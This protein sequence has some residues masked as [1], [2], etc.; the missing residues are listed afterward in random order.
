MEFVT[1]NNGEKMPILG[2]GTYNLR[3]TRGYNAI[4]SAINVGY[5]LIDT[6]QMYGNEIEVGNAVANAIKFGVPREEFFITTKLSSNMTYDEVMKRFED[7]MRKLQL[8]YLDLLLIHSNYRNAKEMYRA[9][10][11]LHKEGKIKSLGVSN[12]NA[13][14]FGDFIKDCEIIPAVNQC[15]T[16]IFYQQRILR[17]AMKESGTI[18][19]SWSPFVSGQSNF[20]KNPTL[21]SVASKYNKSV[22]Q[23][24]LRFL[25]QQGIVVIPKTEN[26]LRMRENLAVFDFSLSGDDMDTLS[27]M[28][29]GKSS[30]SWDSYGAK[31]GANL[32][33]KK[34][35]SKTTR[36]LKVTLIQMYPKPYALS[37]NLRLALK[38][39][40][41]SL[42]KGAN[43]IVF[44]EL[45]DS[46]YCVAPC[47]KD[48][49]LDFT[50]PKNH[51]TFKA[52]S[53]FA[54]ENAVHIVACGIEKSG[55]KL[56]DTAYIIAPS[57]NIIGKH[58]KIYLW[59]DEKS[60][61]YKGKKYEVF[62]LD[63][64]GFRAKVGLQIC[65]E[66]GFGVGANILALKGAE[67]LIYPS[68]FGKARAYN[69]DLLSRARAVEN[70]CF[71]LACNHSGAESVANSP[72]SDFSR[73]CESR[74]LQRTASASHSLDSQKRKNSSAILEF[75]SKNNKDA[76]FIEF[77]GDSRIISPK[78]EIIKK[79]TNLNE[80]VIA[81][82]NLD[83]IFA[84][85]KA[86]PYLKDFSTKLTKRSFGEI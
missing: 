61:F 58:R 16:H 73:L 17:E 5:R 56:Y 8:S 77:A 27:K 22:A 72:R 36:I 34:A 52:L 1:L 43:L 11:S 83:E 23:V 80:A 30:F 81:E 55:K 41:D 32:A 46:G 2:L 69:W 48:F 31:M 82:I 50:K 18:L 79:A 37:E 12:F 63:F 85:R 76:E 47:D 24:A 60:R 71:V 59:G 21:M 84:Q 51:A 4:L 45:F 9:M 39:A 25:I 75:A 15:Q 14:A 67:I 68:A 6:A 28:D 7:S 62:S 54:K 19:E 64:G 42:K 35:K 78:G 20:F 66:I 38:L 86:I 33:N 26:E 44:H 57:G 65:Y 40:N 53:A 3:G 74:S 49:A 13:E 10:V 29:T 70:G